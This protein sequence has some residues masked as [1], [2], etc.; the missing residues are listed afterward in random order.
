MGLL[1]TRGSSS[2]C[3]PSLCTRAIAHNTTWL[4]KEGAQQLAH[5]HKVVPPRMPFDGHLWG[6]VCSTPRQGLLQRSQMFCQAY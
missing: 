2:H 5:T 1:L 6:R 3:L 4:S